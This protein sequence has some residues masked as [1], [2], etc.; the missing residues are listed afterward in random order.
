VL[1]YW[2]ALRIEDEEARASGAVVD[3]PDVPPVLAIARLDSASVMS[4]PGRTSRVHIPCCASSEEELIPLVC[5]GRMPGFSN[6]SN[7]ESSRVVA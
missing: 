3:G 4:A 1:G 2:V 7:R 5:V 6:G